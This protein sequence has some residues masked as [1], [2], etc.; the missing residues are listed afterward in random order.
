MAADDVTQSGLPSF[1]WTPRGTG[2]LVP[3]AAPCTRLPP[4]GVQT[5][6]GKSLLVLD[7]PV[8]IEI[9]SLFGG[10]AGYL[11]PPSRKILRWGILPLVKHPGH[12]HSRSRH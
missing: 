5:N 6:L 3:A 10:G 2:A 12:S 11:P 8:L 1:D 4:Q 7:S 9:L